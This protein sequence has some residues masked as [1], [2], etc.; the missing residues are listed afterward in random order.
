MSRVLF[1]ILHH[2]CSNND[3]YLLQI[4]LVIYPNYFFYHLSLFLGPYS[5][6]ILDMGTTNEK[7]C[8]ILTVSLIS[9]AHIQNDPCMFLKFLGEAVIVA[10]YAYHSQ[11]ICPDNLCMWPLQRF[12]W[13]FQRFI[14]Q[15][16]LVGKISFHLKNNQSLYNVRSRKM[17]YYRSW[18]F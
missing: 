17:K 5:G 7:W 1:L 18:E 8:Y 4:I 13:S 9:W 2:I 6:I 11:R 10:L 12:P 14:P 3:N 15:N 16:F